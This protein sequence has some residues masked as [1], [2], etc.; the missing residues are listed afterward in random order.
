MKNLMLML[1]VMAAVP[2]AHSREESSGPAAAP[3]LEK[4]KQV[5]RRLYEECINPG[6]LDLLTQVVGDDFM[7]PGP[8]KGPAAF[9]KTLVGL[10]QGF[11][12]IAFKVEDLLA[13]GDRVTVRWVWQGTH[14]GPF[15]GIPP[16]QKRVSN[17]GMAI[18]QLRENKIV[19][20]WV[21]TD[22]M[23]FLQDLGVLPKD[24]TA[25]PQ[26]HKR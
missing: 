21:Y 7:G 13:E 15:K 18:Y 20:A 24:S 9:E 12:D 3:T 4:N 6:K 8:G 19:K 11:P 23:G 10:R 26:A 5:V 1:S 22:Q 17:G 16:T 2:P 14:T 25:G